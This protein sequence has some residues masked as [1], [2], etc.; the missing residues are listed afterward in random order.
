MKN[1]A[2][3]ATLENFLFLQSTASNLSIADFAYA[4]NLLTSGRYG[5]RSHDF[6]DV[7]VALFRLS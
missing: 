7:N 5:P 6:H 4:A 1:V 2:S 3:R